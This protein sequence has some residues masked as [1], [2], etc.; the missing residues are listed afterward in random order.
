LSRKSRS[1]KAR[2][3]ALSLK[4]SADSALNQ[5]LLATLVAFRFP[6][7]AQSADR[8]QFGNTACTMAS[9]PFLNA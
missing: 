8:R 9:D 7:S 6:L 1:F 4:P 5:L 2:D 3:K